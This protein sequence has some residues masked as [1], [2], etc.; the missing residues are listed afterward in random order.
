MP[1]TGFGGLSLVSRPGWR[2]LSG[3]DA[4]PWVAA[5]GG[6]AAVGPVGGWAVSVRGAAGAVVPAGG[7]AGGAGVAA[8]E[9][10]AAVVSAGEGS[11]GA[12]VAAGEGAAEGR[13]SAGTDTAAAA[14][15]RWVGAG[16]GPAGGK[17]TTWWRPDGCDR[18]V[19]SVGATASGPAADAGRYR[20]SPGR[21]TRACGRVPPPPE[22][23]T[24]ETM[25]SD[26]P[27]PSRSSRQRVPS[28]RWRSAIPHGES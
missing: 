24:S 21:M 28:P 5:A 10:A 18:A 12:G 22:S 7:V 27:C 4:V 20:T 2:R 23:D 15:A 13:A 19:P 9:G 1:E 17:G 6:A 3:D 14:M 8:G 11:T 26:R 25:T 16:A